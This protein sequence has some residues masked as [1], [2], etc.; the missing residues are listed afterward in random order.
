[1][2]NFKLSKYLDIL[3]TLIIL[4]LLFFCWIRFYTKK[5]ILSA[6]LGIFLSI[7]CVFFIFYFLFKHQKK[8]QI[9]K[10]SYKKSCDCALQLQFSNIKKVVSFF[11]QILRKKYESVTTKNFY[12]LLKN[13]NK[14]AFFIAKF[15]ENSLGLTTFA[16]I[17]ALAKEE[18]VQEIIIC[19]NSFDES[20]K[21]FAKNIKNIKIT[22]FDKFDTYKNLIESSTL[23]PE[24]VVD[25]ST[26]KLNFQQILTS[27][28]SKE[29][30]KHYF[31]M[32][33]ILF[34]FSFFVPYK[35]Y[36]LIVGS[37]LFLMTL[38]TLVLPKIHKK[39]SN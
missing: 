16:K 10:E 24:K 15:D 9:S 8:K 20:T 12:F 3:T 38:I 21:T 7:V 23:L 32:G 34:F 39:K 30:S 35:L 17:F 36:Y 22:L 2:T 33:L 4:F 14:T 27:V 18:K 31:F 13:S 28:L 25:T 1:M 5:P 37:V 29:R 19:S 6:I 26:T 11:E